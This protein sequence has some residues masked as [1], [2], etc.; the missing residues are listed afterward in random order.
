MFSANSRMKLEVN[1]NKTAFKKWKLKN[2]SW[3]HGL[4]RKGNH[5]KNQNGFLN[6]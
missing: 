6:K 1:T 3:T 4:F 5:E 2:N